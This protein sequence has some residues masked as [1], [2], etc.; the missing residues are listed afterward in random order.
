MFPVQQMGWAANPTTP[1]DLQQKAQTLE[2][3]GA[4]P[5]IVVFWG[6]LGMGHETEAMAFKQDIQ[7][8]YPQ[9]EVVLKDVSDFMNPIRRAIGARGYTFMT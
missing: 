1:A 3:T 2:A 5:R 6:S 7:K 9:A 8:A 4:K